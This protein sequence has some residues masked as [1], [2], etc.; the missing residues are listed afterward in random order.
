MRYKIFYFKNKKNK[1]FVFEVLKLFLFTLASIAN[2]DYQ[3]VTKTV[4]PCKII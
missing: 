4:Y 1:L 2:I 3:Q